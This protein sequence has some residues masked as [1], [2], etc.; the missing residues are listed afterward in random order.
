MAVGH[1]EVTNDAQY[2]CS[3]V[4]FDT[5]L[6]QTT[7]IGDDG[8]AKTLTPSRQTLQGYSIVDNSRQTL[9]RAYAADFTLSSLHPALLSKI[10]WYSH[11]YFQAVC[12][13]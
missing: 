5:E 12:I 13:A 8:Q 11:R 6:L 1:A 10:K 3:C 2:L 4:C 9:V 7:L